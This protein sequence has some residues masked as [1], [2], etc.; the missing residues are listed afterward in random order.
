MEMSRSVTYD[1][2]LRN[3]M[4]AV[5]QWLTLGVLVSA[6]ASFLAIQSG[7]PAFFMAHSGWFLLALLAP[8]GLIFV[9]AGTMERASVIAMALA[10]VALTGIEGLTLSVVLVKYSGTVV[11]Q[12]F[13]MTAAAFA[14][15]SLYGYTTGRSLSGLGTILLMSLIGLIV[16]S[17]LGIFFHSPIFQLAICFAGV[18]IFALFMAYDT[19][20]IKSQYRPGMDTDEMLRVTLWGALDLYLDIL[21][22]FLF[23][24]RILGAFSG[25]DD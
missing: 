21:N 12:A 22:F 18:V 2:G 5:Y 9:I 1:Q 7:L 20:T 8:L 14:G 6:G 16:A 11:T 13:L 25:D 3:Y 19:Q 10:Y 24:L 17:I 4:V 15:C 23:V